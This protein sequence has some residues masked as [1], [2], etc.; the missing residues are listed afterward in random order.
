MTTFWWFV[1]IKVSFISAIAYVLRFSPSS[2]PLSEREYESA[3]RYARLLVSEIKLFETYKIE[4][5]LKKNDLLGSL[6]NEIDNARKKFYKQFDQPE[7][8]DEALVAVLADGDAAKLGPGFA[9]RHIK[10]PQ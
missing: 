4:R 1:V 5:G 8:F 10:T 7:I 2:R 6:E 3:K 9:N